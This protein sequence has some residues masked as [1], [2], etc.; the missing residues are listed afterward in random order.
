VELVQVNG[1]IQSQ[2]ALFPYR[3]VSYTRNK[4]KTS[5]WLVNK[6]MSIFYTVSQNV[7]R[8]GDAIFACY[9]K[10][11]EVSNITRTLRLILSVKGGQMSDPT[12]AWMKKSIKVMPSNFW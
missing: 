2:N 10:Q 7:T 12:K 6:N 1:I 4:T 11:G 8:W 5:P 3:S 9:R